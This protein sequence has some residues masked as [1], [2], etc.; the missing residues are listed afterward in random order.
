MRLVAVDIG[1]SEIDFGFF[2]DDTLTGTLAVPRENPDPDGVIRSDPVA[3]DPLP[4]HVILASVVPESVPG[5]TAATARL[6]WPAPRELGVADFPD[7]G[8]PYA[9]RSRFGI[10]RVMNGFGLRLRHAAPGIV[11]DLGT[12]TTVDAVGAGGEMLGGVILPGVGT[13]AGALIDRAPALEDVPVA[14]PSAFPGR[15]TRDAIQAGIYYGAVD[16]VRGAVERVRRSAGFPGT[17]P[18]VA[19]G[20]FSGVL[21]PDLGFANVD[22]ALT[23]YGIRAA[24][25]ELSRRG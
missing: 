16:A 21:A 2:D 17:A 22:P 25:A 5:M 18:V 20:G 13:A 9:D 6:G 1:N 12:A 24:W 19:T 11:V 8:L 3:A 15:S 7:L 23:L 14:K 10:D 4:A